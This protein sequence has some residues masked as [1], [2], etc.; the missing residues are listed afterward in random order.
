[1]EAIINKCALEIK[2]EIINEIKSVARYYKLDEEDVL[3]YMMGGKPRERGVE[4]E[5][6]KRGRPRKEE[7]KTEGGVPAKRG[8]PPKEEKVITV[9]VGEDLISRLLEHARKSA[10]K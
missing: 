3:R 5:Q 1:M 10:L 6:A 9:H 7:E 2:I 8:R 4:E